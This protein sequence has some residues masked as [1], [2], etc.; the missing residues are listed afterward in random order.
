MLETEIKKLNENLAILIGLS[1]NIINAKTQQ[2]GHVYGEIDHDNI[3]ISEEEMVE[4]EH[5]NIEMPT[6]KHMCTHNN[7]EE[8]PPHSNNYPIPHL[9]ESQ[10][11]QEFIECEKPIHLDDVKKALMSLASKVDRESAKNLLKEFGANKLSD[12][13]NSDYASLIAK[14]HTIM[15]G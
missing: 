9:N 11:E 12:L 15:G 3:V 14:A 2:S 5:H 1:N 13:K 6:H 7:L 10:P 4:H 8:F